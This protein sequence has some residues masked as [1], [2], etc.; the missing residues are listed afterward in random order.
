MELTK[1]FGGLLISAPFPI[2]EVLL[3]A[4]LFHSLS[5]NDDNVSLNRYGVQLNFITRLILP[6]DARKENAV[7]S[8]L[9]FAIRAF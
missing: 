3:S 4:G 9:L 2:G 8:V 1:T 7:G 5:A 6:D